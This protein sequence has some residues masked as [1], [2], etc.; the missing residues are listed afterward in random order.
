MI[1]Y[2]DADLR[3]VR[4]V[5]GMHNLWSKPGKS[6]EDPR[7]RFATLACNDQLHVVTFLIPLYSA[8]Y[9]GKCYIF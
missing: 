7:N 2:V 6:F 8:L 5:R 1:V 4:V 3:N 9:L